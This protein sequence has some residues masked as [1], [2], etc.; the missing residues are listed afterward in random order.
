MLYT[1]DL[2]AASVQLIAK[3]AA[4]FQADLDDPVLKV[5]VYVGQEADS[6]WEK[7]LLTAGALPN[8]QPYLATAVA[9]LAGYAQVP[10]PPPAVISIGCGVVFGTDDTIDRVLKAAE[11]V[12]SNTVLTANVA[13]P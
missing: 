2:Q 1:V 13:A 5:Y 8:L 10:P 11:A 9:D 6:G 7:A 3:T 12:V 4:A